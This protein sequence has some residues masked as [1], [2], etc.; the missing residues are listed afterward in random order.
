MDY[1][2]EIGLKALSLSHS[3]RASETCFPQFVDPTSPSH[4]S[5]VGEVLTEYLVL[6]LFHFAFSSVVT[7]LTEYQVA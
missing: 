1:G 7:F 3:A 5:Q 2:D 4:P 6:F